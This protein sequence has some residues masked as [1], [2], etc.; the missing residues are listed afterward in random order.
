VTTTNPLFL[1]GTK[2]LLQERR[3]NRWVTIA[4][5]RL[6]KNSGDAEP[7]VVSSGKFATRKAVGHRLR[8]VVAA[9]SSYGRGV[10]ATIRG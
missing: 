4:K 6:A 2:V 1:T 3:G 8:A 5:T 9:T 10:S 7:T